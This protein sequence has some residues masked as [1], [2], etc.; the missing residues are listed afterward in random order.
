MA[1]NKSLQ[2]FIDNF[3]VDLRNTDLTEVEVKQMIRYRHA[4]H[5]LMECPWM[6]TP[7]LRDELMN[8]YSISESQAYR[9]IQNIEILKGTVQN[10]TREFQLFKINAALDKALELAMDDEDPEAIAKVANII[11]KYNRLDKVE[12]QRIPIEDIIPQEIEFTSDPSIL[13]IKVSERV[14]ANPRAFIDSVIKKY[15]NTINLDN[16]IDYEEIIDE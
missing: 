14:K 8:M 11:G 4:F 12:T 7:K 16:T 6:S 5:V 1:S 15:E 3:S 13:G 2:K 9:D 10:T